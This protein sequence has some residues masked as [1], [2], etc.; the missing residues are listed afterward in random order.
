MA[1][2]F[3]AQLRAGCKTVLDSVKAANAGKLAH[4]YD[5]TVASFRTPL[6]YVDNNVLEP[7]ISHTAG[8][9]GRDLIAQVHLVNKIITNN[10][11]AD[12][13]DVLVDL[14]VDAFTANPNAASATTLIEPI[15]VEGHEHQDGDA[16]YSCSIVNIRGR[17]Q[18]GRN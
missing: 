8:L 13:Q 9:R 6:G 15:S 16:I 12:E 10:Q 17:I 18:E 4:V 1:T 14:V 2:T 11:T 3:R 5:H 7:S